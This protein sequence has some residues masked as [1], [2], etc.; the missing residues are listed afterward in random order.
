MSEWWSYRPS[1]FLM[2]SPRIYWR[3]FEALNREAW[4]VALLAT[5]AA[6][7]WWLMAARGRA[8]GL[9]SPRAMAVLLAAAW[10]MAAW[11]FLLQRF[12][13][14]LWV[15]SAYA[16]LFWLQ[17]A[18]LLMLAWRGRLQLQPAGLCRRAGLGLALAVLLGWPLLAPLAGR[19]GLQAE[20][21]A[22]A[23]DPTAAF[24]LAWLSLCRP[25]GPGAAGLF[26]LAWCLPVAWC[27]VSAATLATMG[28]WQALALV[29]LLLGV[30][31]VARTRRGA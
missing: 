28:S 16:V 26:R 30:T 1:D 13:P 21:L 14:I 20:W 7:A 24:T 6:L 4:P 27:V 15:A 19:P 17:A 23:P 12:A 11:A 8:D 3:L 22:L 18:L 25:A 5:L 29:A 2:F 9:T 10:A 31:V